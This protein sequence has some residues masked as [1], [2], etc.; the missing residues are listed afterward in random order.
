MEGGAE[1]ESLRRK[2]ERIAM[3]EAKRLAEREEVIGVCTTGSIFKREVTETSDIDFIVVLRKNYPYLHRYGTVIE[4]IP[5]WYKIDSS[6][7][8][9]KEIEENLLEATGFL[10]VAILYDPE[11]LLKR[12]VEK[13]ERYLKDKPRYKKALHEYVT[14][15]GK[16]FNRILTWN[17]EG[18][19]V[20]AVKYLWGF[21]NLFQFALCFVNNSIPPAGPAHRIR[22]MQK[23]ERMPE[24]GVD[25]Y[26]KF[27]GFDLV[28]KERA[29]GMVFALIETFEGICDLCQISKQEIPVL[30]FMREWKKAWMRMKE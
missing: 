17:A 5:V 11:R 9:E 26:I 29:E 6:Y 2:Y 4:G 8:F 28:D 20:D 3:D 21:V 27:K 12:S 22:Q 7:L 23:F 30:A 15:M 19:Y 16:S 10:D 25:R 13:V 24:D 18:N 14:S 1:M